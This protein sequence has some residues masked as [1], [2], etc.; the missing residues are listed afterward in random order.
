MSLV[1]DLPLRILLSHKRKKKENGD[2]I[3][4]Y[5][6]INLN[7]YRN[8]N[9]F[10]LNNAKVK[11]KEIIQNQLDKLPYFEWVELE[12]IL[13]PGSAKDMDTM[14]ICS[15]ADKFFSDALVESGKL[16]DDNYRYLRSVRSSC[17]PIDREN[18]RVEV[19]LTGEFRKEQPVQ[20]QALLDHNDFMEALDA[21]VRKTFPVPEGTTPNI[22]ITAGRGD[23]GYSAVVTYASSTDTQP[24]PSAATAQIAASLKAEGNSMARLDQPALPDVTKK[25]E[26]PGPVE[27]L[28]A[29]TVPAEQPA[30][31]PVEDV[32][33]SA[34]PAPSTSTTSLFG[35]K[36]AP[37]AEEAKPLFNI[38]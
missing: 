8:A 28:P 9:F 3:P 21:H 23:K 26:A 18:P 1:L 5:F 25:E 33:P 10:T 13:R 6:Y 20:L 2:K 31:Q 30:A 14:N 29:A 4:N 7:E 32:T 15:I 35:T 12:Y 11:F 24:A 38:G 36:P 22:D 37:A 16:P 34:E 19:I 27:S 17:G